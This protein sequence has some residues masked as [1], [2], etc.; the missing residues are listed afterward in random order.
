MSA[1]TISASWPATTASRRIRRS[2]SSNSSFGSGGGA[3]NS[4]SGSKSARR[5]SMRR[6]GVGTIDTER[7]SLVVGGT[8]SAGVLWL[9]LPKQAMQVNVDE[10]AYKTHCKQRAGSFTWSGNSLVTRGYLRLILTCLRL[11]IK[12]SRYVSR[13][14]SIPFAQFTGKCRAIMQSVDAL[15]PKSSPWDLSSSAR[16]EGKGR[17]PHEAWTRQARHTPLNLLD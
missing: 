5:A 16:K 7:S 13:A 15:G 17:L 10:R 4:K 6:P 2:R 14:Y 1:C 9:W 11:S 12:D 3:T 8:L